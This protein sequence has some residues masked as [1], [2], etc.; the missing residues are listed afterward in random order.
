[1]MRVPDT[2]SQPGAVRREPPEQDPIALRSVRR[3]GVGA[4]APLQ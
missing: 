1:M 2:G 4:L 3:L